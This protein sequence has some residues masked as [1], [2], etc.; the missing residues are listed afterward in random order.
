M[1][2]LRQLRAIAAIAHRRSLAA[3]ARDLHCTP[4]ALSHLIADL[5][6]SLQLTVLRRERPLALTPAGLRLAACAAQVLPAMARA[7]E[8]LEQL[9]HGGAGRLYISLE[10]H[11][12]FEWLVPTLDDF[13]ARHGEVE[14]DL[15]SGAN[16]DPW[17]ALR[18]GSVDVVVSCEGR[19]L[20]GTHADPLF[21]YEMVAV[22]PPRH[23]LAA[24][25]RL[26]PADFAEQTVIT[27]PVD[28]ARLDLYTRFLRPAGLAP[29]RRR[30]AELTA[31]IVQLVAS[32]HG[33]AALPR[34]AVAAAAEA[35]TVV[36]RPLGTGIWS[37]LTL[38][39][40]TSDAG[41]ALLDDF[42]TTA[43]RVSFKTLAGIEPCRKDG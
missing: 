19:R 40:R 25:R 37:Q 29:A 3:A 15:R 22:V 21:R 27:Y 24:K 35:G 5:E 18:D 26:A 16:F 31:M 10:C 32:G 41:S 30:T 9:R 14:L 17:P 12:C 4:S 11:S 7:G 39:R 34:W 43:R 28:E 20:P 33:V 1:I 13:R 36:V 23:A 2:D 42:A 38:L 6:R 8:D